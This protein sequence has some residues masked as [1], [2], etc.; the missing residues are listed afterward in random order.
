MKTAGPQSTMDK[1]ANVLVNGRKGCKPYDGLAAVFIS[2]LFLWRFLPLRLGVAT[3]CALIV[4]ATFIEPCLSE[5]SDSSKFQD[6]RRG[7]L[8]ILATATS[9]LDASFEGL[10]LQRNLCYF[11][12]TFIVANFL[13]VGRVTPLLDSLCNQQS[14]KCFYEIQGTLWNYW[15]SLLVAILWAASIRCLLDKQPIQN[16]WALL[17]GPLRFLC[18]V[19]IT[20]TS[21]RSQRPRSWVELNLVVDIMFAHAHVAAF[22]V[23]HELD[24]L[25]FLF[26]MEAFALSWRYYNGIDRLEILWNRHKMKGHDDCSKDERNGSLRSSWAVLKACVLVPVSQVATVCVCA[27]KKEIV[28]SWNHDNCKGFVSGFLENAKHL[29]DIASTNINDSQTPTRAVLPAELQ[30][31]PEDSAW[32]DKKSICCAMTNRSALLRFEFSKRVESLQKDWQQR[33]LYQVVDSSGG[34]LVF[35]VIRLNHFIRVSASESMHCSKILCPSQVYGLSLLLMMPILH[36][37][38]GRRF[39]LSL[40]KT[41]FN[42]TDLWCVIQYL[43]NDH[44]ASLIVWL[45]SAGS[46]GI[47]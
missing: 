23:I 36:F 34:S 45:V 35:L 12:S 7:T 24:Y 41:K 44:W 22:P 30:Y 31:L 37:L 17:R 39:F 16:L 40:G 6:T 25:L 43:Y 15:A 28:S 20:S 13:A 33:M 47:Y 19:V 11:Y 14:L 26:W 42:R 46:F 9:I 4:I 21:V 38:F 10:E 2:S 1:A 8:L 27:R 18:K 5:M 32:V 3:F 29:S